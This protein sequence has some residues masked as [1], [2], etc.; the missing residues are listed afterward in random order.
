MARVLSG[1]VQGIMARVF[2]HDHVLELA[3]WASVPVI[4]GLSDFSHPCQALTDVFTIWEHS[5]RLEGITVA[6]VR[7][8]FV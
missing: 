6:F 2:A 1:Y 8:N 5:G 3:K 7:N 4:N